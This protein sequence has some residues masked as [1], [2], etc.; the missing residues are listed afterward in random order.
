MEAGLGDL[1]VAGFFAGA[2]AL[3]LAEALL[4]ALADR[5]R[6]VL[7]GGAVVEDVVG[8]VLDG[9]PCG[10]PRARAG[11]TLVE[12]GEGCEGALDALVARGLVA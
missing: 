6:D 9:D 10:D 11:E 12:P 4:G 7:L 1:A 3:L 5:E 2:A 8:G